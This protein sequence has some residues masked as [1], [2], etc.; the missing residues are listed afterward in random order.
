MT[1]QEILQEIKKIADNN[2]FV[3][4]SY[5]GDVEEMKLQP[6]FEYPGFAVQNYSYDEETKT[7]YMSMYLISEDRTLENNCLNVLND[8]VYNVNLKHLDLGI[9][10]KSDN[11]QIITAGKLNGAYCSMQLQMT[12]TSCVCEDK[13]GYV[14][15]VNGQTGDVILD[16]PE[17]EQTV[18]DV[19]GQ[20]GHVV[21]DIPEKLSDLYQDIEYA[22]PDFV[23]EKVTA[24]HNYTDSVKSNLK[25]EIGKLVTGV[26][27]VNGST[28]DVVIFI[29]KMTSDLENNSDF[30]DSEYVDNLIEQLNSSVNTNYAKKSELNTAISDEVSR[31]DN[32]YANKTDIPTDFYTKQEVD[33][34]DKNIIANTSLNFATKTQLNTE[35]AN[36]VSR[37]DNKYAKKTDIPTDFYTKQEVDDKVSTK[38]DVLVSGTNIKTINGKD[39]LGSGDVTIETGTDEGKVKQIIYSEMSTIYLP[40]IV[41]SV[42]NLDNQIIANA[43]INYLLKTDYIAPDVNKEYVDTE[44][45]KL[46][47]GVS[48]V[49]GMTGDVIIETA[50]KKYCFL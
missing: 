11:I 32:K 21:L 5:I 2:S 33:D 45:G 43:S 29:P 4:F 14:S 3:N 23:D 8:I 39:I 24:E 6:G 25:D 15:S 40:E 18:I 28:G 37:A 27:S 19:N 30:I 1:I 13:H 7:Y 10:I 12:L 26:S 16:I 38:Q 35:I 46:V 44:I 50:D 17:I 36:E 9:V 49:N 31:A 47:T 48:S 42:E 41:N 20:T 34:K 22:T